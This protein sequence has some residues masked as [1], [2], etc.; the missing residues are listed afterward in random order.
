[1]IHNTQASTP[2][3]VRPFRGMTQSAAGAQR[4]FYSFAND[5]PVAK[6]MRHGVSSKSSLDVS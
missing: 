2:D 5:P 6:E 3:Q 4:I 1:M